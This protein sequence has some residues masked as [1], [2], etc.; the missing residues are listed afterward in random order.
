[1]TSFIDSK[2][3]DGEIEP[4]TFGPFPVSKPVCAVDG[5]SSSNSGE[6][7]TA[8]ITLPTFLQAGKQ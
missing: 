2:D 8:K 7:K 1:M 5:F 4:D 6:K 3:S